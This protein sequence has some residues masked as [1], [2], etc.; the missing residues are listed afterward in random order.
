MGSGGSVI[1]SGGATGSGGV[2]IGSTGG[3]V[4]TGGQTSAG[5]ASAGSGGTAGQASASGGAPLGG[6]TG[7]GGAS[8]VV[9][10]AGCGKAPPT[11]ASTIGVAAKGLY[12]KF[13]MT[14][15]AQSVL[16][17]NAM[18]G[19]NQPVMREYFVRL[20]DNYDKTKPYRVIYQGQG[21][22]TPQDT[23]PTD[24]KAQPQFAADTNSTAARTDAILVELQQGTY[25]PATY[26][27]GNCDANNMSGC[28]AQSAYCFDDWASEQNAPQV[29]SIPDGPPSGA[30]AME[31]AYFAALHTTIESTYC[32]DTTRQFYSGYSSGGWLAQQLG[33]W[34]PDVLRAQA[35]VTGNIPPIIKAHPEYC[36]QHP[37]AYFSIHNN[38]D[39]S[40]AFQ[41]SVDGA[42]RVFALNGCTG[43]FPTPPSPGVT[44][45]PAGLEVFQITDPTGKVL[46][47]N[48]TT[49][50]CYHYT[51]CPAD[52]PMYFCVSGLTTNQHDAQSANAAPAFWQFF[53]RF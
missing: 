53:S 23:V 13:T 50:R 6:A 1:G 12:G 3:G 42:K 24:V 34:F 8:A 17:F 38:P 35:N 20:P 25:N 10:S 19:M 14:I 39:P 22:N 4:A 15:N 26:N 45:I 31:K 49:F 5:G 29:T 16:Q 51:T 52:Y 18:P 37:I 2:T 9:A 27:Q 48:N 41:G 30:V 43:T 7:A 11:A 21:C 32:V 47:P 44:T 28:N 40:N 33:C 36:V 46:V